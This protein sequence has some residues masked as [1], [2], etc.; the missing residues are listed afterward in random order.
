MIIKFHKHSVNKY[1]NKEYLCKNNASSKYFR[2]FL[3]GTI[4]IKIYRKNFI[5][6]DIIID[7]KKKSIDDVVDILDHHYK[8]YIFSD[9]EDKNMMKDNLQNKYVNVKKKLKIEEKYIKYY[10]IGESINL[11]K[12]CDNIILSYFN[13]KNLSM[14]RTRC[15]RVYK[16]INHAIENNL[17]F[18]TFSLRRIFNLKNLDFEHHIFSNRF[19]I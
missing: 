6:K 8:M 9:S 18:I 12:K 15:M 14:M 17:N 19:Y 2:E 4:K 16:V 7:T 3:E 10:K 11:G 13:V 5:D 1:T